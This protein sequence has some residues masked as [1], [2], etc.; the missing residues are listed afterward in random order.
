M[1]KE[2]E[3]R[4]QKRKVT[5]TSSGQR[6]TP[7]FLPQSRSLPSSPFHPGSGFKAHK[8]CRSCSIPCVDHK[9]QSRQGRRS[10][11]LEL[12][13]CREQAGFPRIREK[14]EPLPLAP[15]TDCDADAGGVLEPTPEEWKQVGVAR[16]CLSE[17]LPSGG[18]TDQNYCIN[19]GGLPRSLFVSRILK[20]QKDIRFFF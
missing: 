2:S 1:R 17:C 9:G 10:V 20:L 19:E 15:D 7:W 11:D 16:C 4:E 3:N 18:P 8:A 13:R 12:E 5:P 14:G 6:P